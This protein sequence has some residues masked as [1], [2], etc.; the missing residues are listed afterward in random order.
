[1]GINKLGILYRMLTLNTGQTPMSIRHQ[2]EILYSDYL[3]QK[4]DNIQLLLEA[5]DKTP[6]KLGEYK[7]K[8]IIEGF[9]SYIERKYLTIDRSEILENIETLEKLSTENQDRDLFIDFLKSYH[10]LVET[11]INKSNN[12]EYN[13]DEIEIELSA[14]SFGKNA[15]KIFSKSQVMTGFGS[16]L[17]KLVDFNK[18]ENINSINELIDKVDFTNSVDTLNKLVIKLDQIRIV[19]KK[20]GNDQR[21]FFHFLFRELFNNKSEAYL[22]LNKAIDEAYS[23]YEQK[24]Q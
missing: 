17:G 3:T 6:R 12:W 7:F 8:E 14:L 19:A 4:I 23:T 13:S 21:M 9:N 15:K 16:A 1:M 24:T 11:F 5:D 18:L 20:I 10:H 2:I 22:N